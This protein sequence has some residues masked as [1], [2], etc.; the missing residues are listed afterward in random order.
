MQNLLA[1]VQAHTLI[2]KESGRPVLLPLPQLPM[3]HGGVA[4]VHLQIATGI[5]Q[6]VA[7]RDISAGE[8]VTVAAAGQRL[9]S[10]MMRQGHPGFSPRLAA[11]GQS[12]AVSAMSCVALQLALEEGD[13]L[14]EVKAVLLRKF[15]LQPAGERFRILADR[16]LPDMLLPYARVAALDERQ[17]PLLPPDELPRLPLESV[18][19][20]RASRLVVTRIEALLAAYPTTLEEDEYALEQSPTART[21]PRSHDTNRKDAALAV[22]VAEKRLLVSLLSMLDR[23]LH[24]YLRSQLTRLSQPTPPT[25]STNSAQWTRTEVASLDRSS[26][27]SPTVA[28]SDASADYGASP[29]GESVSAD[30]PNTVPSS[31]PS[32]CPSSERPGDSKSCSIAS[33]SAKGAGIRQP[34]RPTPR[35]V[36]MTVSHTPIGVLLGRDTTSGDADGKKCSALRAQQVAANGTA[37]HIGV[38]EGMCL[39]RVDELHAGALSVRHVQRLLR[40]ATALKPI[41]I[42][43]VDEA[44]ASMCTSCVD[45]S[46]GRLPL[47]LEPKGAQREPG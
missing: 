34:L 10:L 35:T 1:I 46:R 31:R 47:V 25:R 9:P 4:A 11:V 33:S 13:A 32:A 12:A 8:V 16:P 37:A 26:I 5:V 19:E 7:L 23:H 38:V 44:S 42:Q 39:F 22:L 6:L 30:T 43:F 18:N 21:L 15:G 40:S 41:R 29:S 2:P 28:A 24:D 27:S 17:L 3:E 45:A 36:H 20:E 14:R